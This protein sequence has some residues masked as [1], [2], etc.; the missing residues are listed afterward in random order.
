[1]VIL[2]LVSQQKT[3]LIKTQKNIPRQMKNVHF[4]KVEQVMKEWKGDTI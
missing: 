3:K 2:E 4:K 1:L